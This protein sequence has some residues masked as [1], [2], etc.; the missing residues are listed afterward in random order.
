VAPV[1][2]NCIIEWNVASAHG[3]GIAAYGET[4]NFPGE[5]IVDAQPIVQATIIRNNL[6]DAGLQSS[7]STGGGLFTNSEAFLVNCLFHA[8]T[9]RFQEGGGVAPSMSRSGVCSA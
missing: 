3:G 5:E 7:V 8:N 4:G 6:A 1:I 2:Q 9:A